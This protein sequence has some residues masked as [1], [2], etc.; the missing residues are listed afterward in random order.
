MPET[1]RSVVGQM[2]D[3]IETSRP[4]E[5]ETNPNGILYRLMGYAVGAV[6]LAAFAVLY[7]FFRIIEGPE[8]PPIEGHGRVPSRGR[9]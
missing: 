8:P 5:A 9:R 2:V 1:M 4:F 3:E 6:A 7:G